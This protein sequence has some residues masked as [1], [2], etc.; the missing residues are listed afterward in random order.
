M[1]TVSAP[2]R[3]ACRLPGS[4]WSHQHRIA[5]SLR[6]RGLEVSHWYLPGHWLVGNTTIHLPGVL[7]LAQES[8][9]FWLNEDTSVE[10]IQNAHAILHECLSNE[11]I[12]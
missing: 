10:A 4:N 9:Q 12:I 11:R 6:Y 3:F 1:N 8:F 5:E 2:W 7:K